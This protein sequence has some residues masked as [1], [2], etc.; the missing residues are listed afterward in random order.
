M[1]YFTQ[2]H[3][4][5]DYYAN[6][7]PL[8]WVDILLGIVIATVVINGRKSDFFSEIIKFFGILTAT[9]ISVHYYERFGLLIAAYHS[10]VQNIGLLLAF[11]ILNGVI[12]AMFTILKDS[13]RQIL[14]FEINPDIDRWISSFIAIIRSIFIGGLIFLALLISSLPFVMTSA[15]ESLSYYF[16]KDVS[17][18]VY[19][20]FLGS[21]IDGLFP[22]EPINEDVFKRVNKITEL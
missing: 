4:L 1:L 22:N 19:K 7:F 8:N 10:A 11:C 18:G 13:W 12:I 15:R 5:P 2:S 20:T 17:A 16:F 3:I 9:F 21:F 14:S 6:I